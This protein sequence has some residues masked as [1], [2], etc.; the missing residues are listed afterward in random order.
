MKPTGYEV[1]IW[2]SVEDR[3]YIAEVPEL[4]G[5]RADGGSLPEVAVAVE[6][7]IELRISEMKA[8]GLSIP[9]PRG[10]LLYA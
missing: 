4:S 2:W 3:C 9:A 5:C 6:K 1:I 7:S 8:Q 10:R